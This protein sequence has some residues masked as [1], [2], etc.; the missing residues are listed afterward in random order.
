VDEC[1]KLLVPLQKFFYH[2][3]VRS[4]A[5]TTMPHLLR[6]ASLFLQ[7]QGPGAEKAYIAQLFEFMI[8]PMVAAMK[9]EIDMEILVM[10][11]E[12]LSESLDLAEGAIT[13]Q[14]LQGI[15][16]LV[17]ELLADVASRRVERQAKQNEEDHDDEEAEKLDDESQHDEEIVAG[18]AEILGVLAKRTKQ[19]V[20]PFLQPL[21][22]A[23]LEMLKPAGRISDRQAALC[24]FDDLTEH[25]GESAA[26]LF[27]HF[28]PFTVQ[29]TSDQDPRVRQ[30]AVYGVGVAAQM[31]PATVAPYI[32]DLLSRLSQV[33]L[34]VDSRGEDYAGPTENAI[35]AVGKI[36]QYHSNSV[37]VSKVLPVW[38]SWLP[39]TVDE[40]ESK[41][42]YAQLCSFIESSNPHILGQ[43]YANLPKIL[44]IFSSV[45]DT[46]L[47]DGDLTLRM[48]NI[49]KQMQTSLPAA[50]QK[51]VAG[52]SG[53][54][55]QKLLNALS[56]P[57][58]PSPSK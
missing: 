43:D 27:Q 36:C 7:K 9:E 47:V 23:F 58:V 26:P 34:S 18:L 38:L 41:V 33:I 8:G 52:L 51:A 16:A 21:L 54:K 2:D 15:T 49:L 6:S 45:L 32:P 50:A 37:D 14:H 48:V 25:L 17:S 13:V 24:V 42:T 3:G 46:N 5:I 55:Q 12:S 22:P 31:I 20:V 35:A 11:V 29:Y 56:A 10:A 53:E 1:A 57:P 19:N 30:A 44:D 28:F 39:V 40:V 4:A